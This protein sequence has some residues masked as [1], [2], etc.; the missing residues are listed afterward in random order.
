MKKRLII[1]LLI[2]SF[3]SSIDAVAKEKKITLATLNWA[4][5][6]GKTLPDYGFNADLVRTILERVGYNLDLSFMPWARA[7]L[8]A[9]KGTFDGAFPAYYSKTRDEN[10]AYTKSFA[11]S[12]VV[13]CTRADADINYTG[14]L[15]S[16]KG[17]LIGTIRGFVNS[18]EF[19]KATYLH[20][21]QTKSDLQNLKKLLKGRVDLIVIDKFVAISI[22]K[23]NPYF[24]GD[25]RSVKFLEPPLQVKP[26]YVIFSYQ[27]SN[28]EKKV[29][30]F[31]KGLAEIKSDG[32]FKQIMQKHGVQ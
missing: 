32:T 7:M 23:N 26:L 5:Y 8:S 17:Y 22:L 9:K 29:R 12:P 21:D 18:P 31:N 30:A 20:K 16:L 25:V 13:F 27:A 28:Y 1:I 10:F 4:P 11:Q 6:V 24:Q 3:F 19:D 2:L 14:D 15:K